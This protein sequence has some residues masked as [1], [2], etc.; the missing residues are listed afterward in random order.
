MG[1]TWIDASLCDLLYQWAWKFVKMLDE[2]GS[3]SSPLHVEPG[4]F[5]KKD[6]GRKMKRRLLVTG[7]SGFIGKRLLQALVKQNGGQDI[8]AFVRPSTD[9]SLIPSGVEIVQACRRSGC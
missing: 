8:L 4:L 5:T 9:R 2:M 3:C 6:H 7:G 1:I